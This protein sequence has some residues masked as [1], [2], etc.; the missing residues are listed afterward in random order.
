[1]RIDNNTYPVSYLIHL[2]KPRTTNRSPL[3]KIKRERKG[4]FALS[5][6]LLLT[7][8]QFNRKR[9][10][11][12]YF[13]YLETQPSSIQVLS[14]PLTTS[15]LPPP[16]IRIENCST[17]QS[18]TIVNKN[19][20]LTNIV[21]VSPTSSNIDDDTA[22]QLP[23]SLIDQNKPY[24]LNSQI[25]KSLSH[26]TTSSPN[27]NL[28][29]TNNN[30][31]GLSTSNVNDQIHT[32][33]TSNPVVADYNIN[34]T[35]NS[36]STTVPTSSSTSESNMNYVDQSHYVPYGTTQ[37][38][39]SQSAPPSYHESVVKSSTTSNNYMSSMNINGTDWTTNPNNNFNLQQTSSSLVK[40]EPQDY[41]MNVRNN[42]T[43]HFAKPRNYTN[44]PSKTPVH[45]RPFSC[46]IEPCPRR[47]SRSDE[48]TRYIKRILL[49][50]LSFCFFIDTFVFIQVINHF[51]V[52][53]VLVHFQDL[54]I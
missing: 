40:D 33:L 37:T 9:K 5:L 16:T 4:L 15:L 10:D 29:D 49:N 48:L 2:K 43:I 54:I 30:N 41:P 42:Q 1:M 3:R 11:F 50:L 45:E 8:G 7:R 38:S 17:N 24:A 21:D 13:L 23:R 22:M 6:F 18:S 34:P 28:N 27:S 19:S 12:I 26:L 47:F 53:F 36:T 35:N 14:Q 25:K 51:N 39:V 20:T 31:N 44:R 46:P 32:L 52:K